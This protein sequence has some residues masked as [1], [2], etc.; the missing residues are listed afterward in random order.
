[1]GR[2]NK[3]SD[4]V[5]R[6]TLLGKPFW[7]EYTNEKL[8]AG[9]FGLFPSEHSKLKDLKKQN[10]RDHMTPLELIF[11]ALSEETTRLFAIRDEAEGFDENY[12][13]AQKSGNMTGDARRNYEQKTGLKVVSSENFLNLKA[14]EKEQTKE[15]PAENTAKN[16]QESP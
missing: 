6:V 13:V 11:T 3:V 15:L 2:A 12:D 4:V 7:V 14:E 10:L 16:D 9:T 1:M 8:L 5:Q